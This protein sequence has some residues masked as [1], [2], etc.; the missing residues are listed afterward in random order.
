[1]VSENNDPFRKKVTPC[2]NAANP[3]CLNQNGSWQTA[4]LPGLCVRP[5]QWSHH[6]GAKPPRARRALRH[7]GAKSVHRAHTGRSICRHNR[8]SSE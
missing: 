3:V 2:R 5:E 1:M 4:G 6:I 8:G 7:I